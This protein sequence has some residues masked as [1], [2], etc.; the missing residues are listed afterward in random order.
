MSLAEAIK[1]GGE[2]N[3]HESIEMRCNSVKF[4]AFAVAAVLVPSRLCG[5]EDSNLHFHNVG[6]FSPA[7]RKKFSEDPG[8]CMITLSQESTLSLDIPLPTYF[9]RRPFV[10]YGFHEDMIA[11]TLFV[12]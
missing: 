2:S 3:S 8:C 6:L 9:V 1:G 4:V 5:A 12:L 10:L 7:P 11:F